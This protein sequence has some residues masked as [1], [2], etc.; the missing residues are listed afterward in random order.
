MEKVNNLCERIVKVKELGKLYKEKS[1]L[2][3]I[4][5][6][7]IS[8]ST[9]IEKLNMKY[10]ELK[11][12]LHNYQNATSQKKDATYL[13]D[14]LNNEKAEIKKE[15]Y[16]IQRLNYIIV[17]ID[18]LLN[19]LRIDWSNYKHDKLSITEEIIRKFPTYLSEQDRRIIERLRSQI[20]TSKP[21][22]DEGIASLQSILEIHNKIIDKLNLGTIGMNFIRRLS[23]EGSIAFNNIDKDTIEWLI[24]S[25]LAS[26]IVLTLKSAS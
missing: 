5:Q 6:E 19:A 13:I 12:A 9:Q 16:S 11:T 1:N 8:Y 10:K 15:N 17:E 22:S 23:R 2:E 4:N 7:L 24:K 20:E 26:K 3:K 21:F 14:I 18:R 25:D